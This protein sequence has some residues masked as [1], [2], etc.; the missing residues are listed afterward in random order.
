VTAA[1]AV[2][3]RIGIAD[4]AH[5]VTRDGQHWLWRTPCG[6]TTRY[7]PLPAPDGVLRCRA[8]RKQ[9]GELGPGGDR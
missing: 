8:C 3:A 4:T 5:H 7:E 6:R 2:W 1:P 9:L